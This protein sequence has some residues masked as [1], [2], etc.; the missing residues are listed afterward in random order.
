ME[1]VVVKLCNI[2]PTNT[3]VD[4]VR[5][6]RWSLIQTSY[7]HIRSLVLKR[8]TIITNTGIQLVDINQ[9]TLTNWY[10]YAENRNLDRYLYYILTFLFCVFQNR[11]NQK[12]KNEERTILEQ[13]ITIVPP[14]MTSSEALPAALH[15]PAELES[16]TGER[17]QFTFPVNAAGR[18]KQSRRP[19]LPRPSV[20]SHPAPIIP[21]PI[22]AIQTGSISVEHEQHVPIPSSTMAYRRKRQHLEET[23]DVKRPRYKRKTGTTCGQCGMER[24]APSHRQYYGKWWCET[25]ADMP[26]DQWVAAHKEHRSKDKNA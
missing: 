18:A 10:E 20:Q 15:L 2:V 17:H 9:A 24:V 19:I 6:S 7:Q 16:G 25:K 13:G 4:G 21:A 14:P 26:Y 12:S 23:G 11:F 5:I 1:A 3:A 22:A 8:S